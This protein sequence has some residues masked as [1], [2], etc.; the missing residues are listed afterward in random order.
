MRLLVINPV[1]NDA[2][3][4][5]VQDAFARK[6]KTAAELTVTGLSEGPAAI[7][8]FADELLAGP[9]VLRLIAREEANYDGFFIN[10]F[11]DVAMDGAREIT[12]K[13]VLGAGEAAYYLA[14]MTGVP[15]SIVTIGS[16][17]RNKNGYRFRDLGCPRFVSSTGVPEGVLALNS[18]PEA[19]AQH[20][21]SAFE[22]E[23][24]EK[25]SELLVLGC[26][27]M[28]DVCDI[29]RSRLSCPV[30]EPGTA[31]VLLLETFVSLGISHARSGK[32]TPC[33][34]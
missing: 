18:D 1:A 29:V 14:A 7:E 25:G 5:M 12:D 11:G 16:N 3:N 30:I 2:F 34:L 10:C 13:P 33:T 15:F 28:I 4:L 21:I 24:A 22:K 8:G 20:I 9:V 31:G 17:A 27:G 6:L 23:R 26:T 19:T 32:Y